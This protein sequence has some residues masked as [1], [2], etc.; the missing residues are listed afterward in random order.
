MVKAINYGR[1][2]NVLFQIACCISYSIK[3]GLEFSVQNT[4]T[5]HIWNPIYLQHLVNPNWDESKERVLI[6]EKSFH[7][8][9]IEF[10]EEWRGKNIILDGYWQSPK[11]FDFCRDK[12]L[13]LFNFP[14]YLIPEVCSVHA[15]YGDYLTIEG[16][17]IIMNEEYLLKAMALM[18]DKTGIVRYKVFSDDLPYFKKN[19]GHL[20]NFE[21]SENKNEIDDLVEM[22]CCHNSINSSSTFSWWSAWLNRN[23]DK[24]IIT[25]EFWFQPGWDNAITDDL[26]PDTW[27]KL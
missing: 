3:H 22:S 10:K 5:H 13:Q 19:L 15:R 20:Y 18:K 26:I 16:K 27:I 14:Y 25:P 7:Y 24:V 12:I 6:Q 21:Y 4:S 8:Q 23:P 1:C 9:P 11:F 17:H 2:G